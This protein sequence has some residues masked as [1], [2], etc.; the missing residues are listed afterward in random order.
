MNIKISRQFIKAVKEAA[1]KFDQTANPK[2]FLEKPFGGFFIAQ[3]AQEEVFATFN[4]K[5]LIGKEGENILVFCES[6][7]GRK[8]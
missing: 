1:L 7:L 8:Q 2:V 3:E 6:L 5:D 4:H